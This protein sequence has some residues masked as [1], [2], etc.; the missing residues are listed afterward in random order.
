MPVQDLSDAA[1][2]SNARILEGTHRDAGQSDIIV[3]SA[4]AKQRDGDT[5]LDLIGRNLQIL[6]SVIDAMQ[7]LR[8]DAILL[9]VANPV[10]VLTHFAQ[11]LSGLPKKQ[12][13]GSGTSLDSVR[14]AGTLS[15]K[16]EVGVVDRDRDATRDKA[17]E[18]IKVK[19]FTSCGV[20]AV[21]STICESIIF[22]QRQVLPLS[23]WQ[24][25]YKCCL[26][27]PA[28]LG[29][30]GVRSTIVLP[31]NEKERGQL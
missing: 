5:R 12:V 26:S 3:V 29:K 18:I 20:A 16:L 22:D 8:R 31:L 27:L 30:A 2:L 17:Y 15:Q 21:V 13:L 7:P 23:H 10:D 1:S 25:E 9:L 19:G 4:G 11:Q 6:K 28:V 14:L 24:E